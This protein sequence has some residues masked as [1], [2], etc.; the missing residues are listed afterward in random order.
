MPPDEC[1]LTSAASARIPTAESEFQLFFYKSSQDDKEHLALVKGEEAGKED[2]LVRVHSECFTGDVLGSKRCDCGA[3]LQAALKL[4]AEA[5]SGVVIYLRQEGRGIGLLDKLR[6]YN[7]QDQGYDTV[8]ANLLLGHQAD[9]RDYTVAAQILKDLGVSSIKLLTNN[10][11]KIDS[12]QELGIPV[13]ARIPLQTGVCPENAKYLRTKARRMKHLLVLDEL[14]NGT[15][16]YQPIKMGI[17]EQINAPLHRAA[18]HR[19]RTGRPFVTLS[20]AQSLDGSIAARPGRPLALSGSKSMALTHGLRATHEGILVGIGTLLAD[21]PRLN[22]RLVE[23]KDPQPIVVDSRLRFPPYA[24]LLRNGRIPW[25][26]TSA[27]ADPE[28]QAALEKIGTLAAAHRQASATSSELAEIEETL[29]QADLTYFL[30]EA[31]RAI[32]QSIEGVARVAE[33]VRA[34]KD[35]SHPGTSDGATMDLNHAVESTLTVSRNEWKYVA[36][37]ETRL[38]P[39]LP[40]VRA[41]LGDINQVVLNLVVNAAHAVT[42]AL[43]QGLRE[44]GKILVRTRRDGNWAVLEVEDT[45]IGIPE[46]IQPH[47]FTPFFTTKEVGQGTGQGLA[48]ARALIVQKYKGTITFRS[49]PGKGTVFTV[50]LPLDGGADEPAAGQ[51][52]PQEPL[53]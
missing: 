17:L 46:A 23:G 32:E 4:V 49:E 9:E 38:A 30:E 16:C 20:Y 18:A 37:L 19:Q 22:V 52:A 1:P 3:Q 44:R 11:H 13:A 29:R 15:P 31:P 24:N 10:P 28:R 8:D 36:D 14:P 42:E 48:L 51:T 40:P 6:A 34:M 41:R 53:Q 2:V 43:R 25:I 27:E 39:D 35:F 21:D 45:G 47:I 50:R 7:L 26:A 12:L 5:G 33:I